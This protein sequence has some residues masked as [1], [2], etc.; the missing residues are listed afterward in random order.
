[1]KSPKVVF[2]FF[3]LSMIPDPS[4]LIKCTG[5]SPTTNNS[6]ITSI[7]SGISPSIHELA[8]M[9]SLMFDDAHMWI[10]S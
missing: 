7:G 10:L 8:Y 5:P 4:H 9:M 6:T 2:G 1:M 3:K